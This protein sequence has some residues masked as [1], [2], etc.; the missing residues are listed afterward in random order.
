MPTVVPVLVGISYERRRSWF[1]K[2]A[3]SN[4]TLA[5]LVSSES[6]IIT[7]GSVHRSPAPTA[8]IALGLACVNWALEWRLLWTGESWRRCSN[9]RHADATFNLHCAVDEGRR[10]HQGCSGLARY[11][12]GDGCRIAEKATPQWAGRLGNVCVG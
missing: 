4:T 5:I 9:Q 1:A 7:V 3:L 10:Q 2:C 6:W 11:P 12:A 8:L